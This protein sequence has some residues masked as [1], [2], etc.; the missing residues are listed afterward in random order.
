MSAS[1]LP[2]P[3]APAAALLD[4]DTVA[5]MLDCSAR[6]VYRLAGAGRMPAPV[7]LGSLVRWSRVVIERWI[8]DG[9]P[10][11]RRAIR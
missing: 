6:H 10:D 9:C 1:T 8:G 5:A 3:D 7:R 2:A 11:C 4:V